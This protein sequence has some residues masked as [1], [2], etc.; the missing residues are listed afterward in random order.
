MI[1][2]FCGNENQAG[3]RFCGMCGVRLERRKAERR[4]HES[5]ST[6]CPSCGHMNE[7]RYKFCGMC[8]I[9]IDR[10]VAERRGSEQKVRATA[11]ANAQLPTPEPRRNVAQPQ[12]Q[13]ERRPAPSRAATALAEHTDLEPEEPRQTTSV[14]GPSFLGLNDP[15]PD[16]DYLLEEESSSGGGVRTLILLVILVAIIG[17]IY[18][19]YRAN[20]NANPKPANQQKAEPATAPQPRGSNQQKTDEKEVATVAGASKLQSAATS[21]A[22]TT[23]SNAADK[24][25]ASATEKN[26]SAGEKL[27]KAKVPAEPVD[28]DPAPS[29]ADPAS[30]KP[31]AALVK[32]QKYL[33]GQGVRQNCEQG[34]MYLKAATEENDPQA[35]VQMAA[36][37]SSGFCVEQDRV[38]AY[39]WF[40][41][42]QEMN[43]DN[44]WIAK[45]MSQ[46][47]AQMTPSERRQAR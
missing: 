18:A 16:G 21:L 10:R 45:N 2:T 42:A 37:Y 40:S 24:S 39:R 6:K 19:Q 46:L 29:K 4:V 8:G 22:K 12:F 20:S 27:V 34:L 26:A 3:N 43:P 11:M 1:C 28:D 44:R 30:N 17:L 5:G 13:T 14:G 32:A 36:L 41:S 23:D 7:P 9:R 33:H 15:Q 35:A 31:S 25:S 47:W 38:K